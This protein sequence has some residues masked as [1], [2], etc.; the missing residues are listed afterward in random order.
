MAN[1]APN[2][3]DN[4]G[5]S[6][7]SA[8]TGFSLL[9]DDSV[10]APVDQPAGRRKEVLNSPLP[11]E[12]SVSETST[13]ET[14]GS[15]TL[16]NNALANETSA[17][18]ETAPSNGHLENLTPTDTAPPEQ[19]AD[20]PTEY[21]S[22]QVELEPTI[23]KLQQE[24][25]QN[26]QKAPKKVAVRQENGDQV[27]PKTVAQPVVIL[28]LTEEKMDAARKKNPTYS[29]K[30]LYTWAKRQIKKFKDILVVYRD[31]PTDRK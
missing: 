16:S 27:V 29:I 31:K 15:E 9:T 2:P 19:T 3:A 5:V 22:G 11:G 13:D 28:P 14:L 25:E 7:Q 30:W 4:S 17:T 20:Q 24:I 12:S 8:Q 26:K 23:E 10:N 6:D 21:E 18:S 1:S